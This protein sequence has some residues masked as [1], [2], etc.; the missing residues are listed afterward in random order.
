MQNCSCTLVLVVIAFSNSS[1][2]SSYE[3]ESNLDDCLKSQVNV[4]NRLQNMILAC[5][6]DLAVNSALTLSDS[7]CSL[8]NVAMFAGL[9]PI[10]TWQMI[11]HSLGYIH[12]VCCFRKLLLCLCMVTGTESQTTKAF[13]FLKKYFCIYCCL[14]SWHSALFCPW[15]QSLGKLCECMPLHPESLEIKEI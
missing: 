13:R 15:I 9:W 7:P 10:C 11:L 4:S 14:L 1:P 8:R 3:N 2:G 6:Y 5:S 12:P